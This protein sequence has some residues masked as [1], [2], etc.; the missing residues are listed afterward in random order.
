LVESKV[1]QILRGGVGIPEIINY[2]E[3]P[4]SQH[5]H[6]ITELLG[7]NLEDL[8]NYCGRKFTLKTV[9]MIAE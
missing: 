5:N 2:G 3:E 7:P 4:N 1:L 6:L 8:F 9:C